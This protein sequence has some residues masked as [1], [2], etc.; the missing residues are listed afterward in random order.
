[1]TDHLVVVSE[2]LKRNVQRMGGQSG[3]FTSIILGEWKREIDVLV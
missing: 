2:A 3:Y 1:M